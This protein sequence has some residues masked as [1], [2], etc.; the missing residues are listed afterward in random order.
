MKKVI[1]SA[2]A[3]LA[4][5]GTAYAGGDIV[6]VAPMPADSWSGFYVGLQAGGNWGDADVNVYYPNGNKVTDFSLNPDGWNGGLYGGYNWLLDNNIL[7]GIEGDWS[8]VDA[9]DSDEVNRQHIDKRIYGYKVE[10]DW[11]ASLRLR[12]GYVIDD[13]WM[14]Y[15]TGGAAWAKVKGELDVTTGRSV[16]HSESDSQ[17]MTGWTIGAGVEMKIDENWHARI[18]YRYTDYGDDDFSHTINGVDYKSNVDYNTHMVQVGISY[19]F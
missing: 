6:P 1:I 18:Q 10:Q 13:T 11:D 8:Y 14:P 4:L 2:V 9:D 17:T 7:L 5:S 15:I 3:A 12:A 19:R 16:S